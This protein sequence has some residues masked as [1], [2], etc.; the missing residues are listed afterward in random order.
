MERD[1]MRPDH[2]MLNIHLVQGAVIRSHPLASVGIKSRVGNLNGGQ[3][4]RTDDHGSMINVLG[5][6]G[7]RHGVS[8]GWIGVRVDG[9]KVIKQHFVVIY[10]GQ[11]GSR[12][13]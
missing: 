11:L 8:V 4:S 5:V 7:K 2:N 10:A 9:V 3:G 1:E 13:D 12:G 6:G